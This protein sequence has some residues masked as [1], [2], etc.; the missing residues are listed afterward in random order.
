MKS[1]IIFRSIV[2]G[3]LGFGACQP[4]HVP[5]D[6]VLTG[7]WQAY[8]ALQNADT[9]LIDL[10]P[11]YLELMENERY[12][13]R[14]VLNQQEAGTWRREKDLLYTLDTTHASA[15]KAMRI[16]SYGSDT[17][18]I[19]MHRD[20]HDLFLFLNRLGNWEQGSSKN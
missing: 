11:I 6:K 8:C 10:K 7:K 14:G 15:E 2:L 5:S 3:T 4:E 19:Q 9:L 13:F 1:P 17:L 12:Q 20:G 16:R 18:S